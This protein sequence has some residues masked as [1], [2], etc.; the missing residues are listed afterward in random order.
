MTSEKQIEA[1]RRNAQKSTGPAT[2]EGKQVVAQNAIKH[3]LRSHRTLIPGENQDEF[4]AFK[5]DLIKSINPRGP[6]EKMLAERIVALSWKLDR[7][8]R[9]H[10]GLINDLRRSARSNG[11]SGSRY[12]NNRSGR[13]YSDAS[14]PEWFQHDLNTAF[15]ADLR[16][17]NV[18][19]RMARY[20]SQIESSLNRAIAQLHR[21]Q[22]AREKMK[23]H[24]HRDERKR[25]D[26]RHRDDRI[27]RLI[28]RGLIRPYLA[29]SPFQRPAMNPNL[30]DANIEN[31]P[32]KPISPPLPYKATRVV[33]TCY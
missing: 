15:K 20:E 18:L 32:N 1:N 11:S 12:N 27:E 26:Q 29:M 8:E 33:S 21:I 5:D 2:P 30:R 4:E 7:A 31:S 23:Y 19:P 17:D 24:T 16:S 3:G 10:S 14:S 13:R 25:T 22:T 28:E 9:I 6:L